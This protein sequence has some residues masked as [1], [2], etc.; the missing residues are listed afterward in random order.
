M[1]GKTSSNRQAT[2]GQVVQAQNETTSGIR[3]EPLGAPPRALP[4]RPSAPLASPANNQPRSLGGRA[5][6]YRPLISFAQRQREELLG[7]ILN[8][9]SVAQG[10]QT[11]FVQQLTGAHS[12][13]SVLKKEV[14][15]TALFVEAQ[16][17]IAKNPQ[18][19]LEELTAIQ[20]KCS[21]GKEAIQAALRAYSPENIYELQQEFLYQTSLGQKTPAQ[22]A[23]A[24]A[25][26]IVGTDSYQPDLEI[27]VATT[28]GGAAAKSVALVIRC[29]GELNPTHAI[30]IQH[31][32][33][34]AL[35]P[36]PKW[37]GLLMFLAGVD[38]GFRARGNAEPVHQRQLQP[39]NPVNDRSVNCQ[40]MV[41][42]D[43]L[44][45]MMMD[46][47]WSLHLRSPSPQITAV[48]PT[49]HQL[50]HDPFV[51]PF[52]A[53]T[54]W[55]SMDIFS[56]DGSLGMAGGP[57]AALQKDL[58]KVK[59][60]QVLQSVLDVQA[61]ER[62]IMQQ[63][64]GLVALFKGTIGA[65]VRFVEAQAQIAQNPQASLWDIQEAQ[66]KCSAGHDAVL[67]VVSAYSQEKAT[68]V[69]D[70][71]FYEVDMKGQSP[72]QAVAAIAAR[73][74]KLT[75]A[76]TDLPEVKAAAAC[77]TAKISS[78]AISRAKELIP[79]SE[80][81]MLGGA[82]REEL[83]KLPEGQDILA[84]VALVNKATSTIP[85]AV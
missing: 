3:Q 30:E 84:L 70:E 2:R 82:I 51:T 73:A 8:C 15:S 71:M 18:V 76:H 28:F 63:A 33:Y 16:A 85:T 47:G 17:Q 14:R 68:E 56:G 74:L 77:A 9:V 25:V 83:M 22:A 23:A 21:A 12:L 54:G 37:Q 80:R 67:S 61:V 6:S 75:R 64:G 79:R 10:A 39:Q 41:D 42:D 69:R 38:E 44:P 7:S 55:G 32:V 34:A 65:V 52:S 57:E 20:Q 27:S 4:T 50:E 78:L 66:R 1:L 35:K 62:S 43:S 46:E 19:S 24:V 45:D 13:I 5:P 58:T 26:K 11:L 48:A 53:D 60:A 36:L 49:I 31:A 59:K 40:E 29:A 72:A 81:S